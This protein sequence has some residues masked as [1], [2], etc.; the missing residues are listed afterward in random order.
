MNDHADYKKTGS[1][2]HGMD[3]NRFANNISTIRS[4]ALLW[5]LPSV[6]PSRNLAEARLKVLRLY[7]RTCR[8]L[9]FIIRIWGFQKKVT[10]PQAKVN[11]ANWI[12]QSSHLRRSEDIDE[13]VT[14]GIFFRDLNKCF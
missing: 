2:Y 8:L 11:I 1:A 7:T 12:R 5:N 14:R 6:K 3:R 10:V 9:P 13:Q 4:D